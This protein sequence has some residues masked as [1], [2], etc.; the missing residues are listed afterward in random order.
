LA[1]SGEFRVVAQ[2]EDEGEAAFVTRA[3]AAASELSSAAAGLSR[4]ILVCNERMDERALSDRQQVA[5]EIFDMSAPARKPSVVLVAS[6]RASAGLRQSLADL[7]AR[8]PGATVR[9]D[10]QSAPATHRSIA[11]VA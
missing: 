3:L 5:R 7:A 11:N 10:D 2:R 4:A 8:I 1:R 6:S 9:V